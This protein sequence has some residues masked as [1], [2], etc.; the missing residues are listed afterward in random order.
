MIQGIIILVFNIVKTN[1]NMVT[2]YHMFYRKE[3]ILR[4]ELCILEGVS[5][6]YISLGKF[7]FWLCILET[8][9]QFFLSLES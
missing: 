9:F 8:E 5:L 3:L 6:N 2:I 7:Y 1:L 4:F